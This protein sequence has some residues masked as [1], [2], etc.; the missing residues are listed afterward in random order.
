MPAWFGCRPKHDERMSSA[1]PKHEN[2]QYMK[3]LRPVAASVSALAVFLV[4]S[5]AAAQSALSGSQLPSISGGSVLS[6]T[7]QAPQTPRSPTTGVFCIEEMTA[8][9]CNVV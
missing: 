5:P 3:S 8:T 4:A 7:P 9:F 1:R 6:Q 2:E